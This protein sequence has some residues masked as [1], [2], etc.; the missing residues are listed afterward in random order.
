MK[1]AII[2][3]G[4]IGYTLAYNLINLC[5]QNNEIDIYGDDNCSF[6][7]SRAAG[8]MLNILSEVDIF[9]SNSKISK[10]KLEN[11]STAIQAWHDLENSFKN[12]Q[13]LKGNLIKGEGTQI[14]ID[15]NCE[16]ELEKLN[17]DE[18]RLKAKQYRIETREFKK[19]NFVCT[20][21]PQEK[22]VD[23]NLYMNTLESFLEK[24]INF[25]RN[26]VIKIEKS[27]NK[28]FVF[29][30]KGIKKSFTHIIVAAGSWSQEILKRSNLASD[31]KVKSYFGIGSA[32]DLSSEF[33]NYEIQER[34]RIYRSPNRG[35][36]CGIHFVQRKNSFYV[37]ASSMVCKKPHK[38]PRLVSIEKLIQ[39][40]NSFLEIDIER[41]SSNI[42][43]GY[44][45]VT[46]DFTP[47][48]GEIDKN[49]LVI[50][51]T[52]RDGF[53]WAPYITKHCALSL[54][55]QTSAEWEEILEI[56]NP[57]R[58]IYS[59]GDPEKCIENYIL[60]KKYAA[61]QH[62][63]Y[64]T[65]KEESELRNIAKEAHRKIGIK[66]FGIEPELINVIFYGN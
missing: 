51:G 38:L 50:Y 48:I 62:D 29:D 25:N 5:N 23:S 45:P 49:L 11:H 1:I 22:S 64:I 63:K 14:Q 15:N 9:N 18:I 61:L 20:L 40:A 31:I 32:L 26:N 42:L 39:G 34:D 52:K 43:T 57:L 2:G 27:E 55:N 12:H 10:F 44:R 58:K 3:R 19:G 4:S 35:G 36:T 66:N 30:D 47:I 17:Y 41:L 65:K 59:A 56:C 54:I 6:S 33:D 8:A 46:S 16:N 7:A 28:W 24:K 53:T 13:I 21:I 37:G 60:N